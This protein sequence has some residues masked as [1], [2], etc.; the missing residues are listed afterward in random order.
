M[1]HDAGSVIDSHLAIVRPVANQMGKERQNFMEEPVDRSEIGAGEVQG[2][3]QL[4]LGVAS[5][6][7]E[8]EGAE[9]ALQELV[10]VAS[11]RNPLDREG[12]LI[13]DL[14]DVKIDELAFRPSLDHVFVPEVSQRPTHQHRQKHQ[15]EDE[16]TDEFE[17]GATVAHALTIRLDGSMTRHKNSGCEFSGAEFLEDVREGDEHGFGV[18]MEKEDPALFSVDLAQDLIEEGRGVHD[19]PVAGVHVPLK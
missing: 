19:L 14:T 2:A 6:E 5:L 13:F 17:V 1:N 9:V 15:P 18:F 12:E 7:R 3:A 4:K 10:P 11:D 16:V 8:R